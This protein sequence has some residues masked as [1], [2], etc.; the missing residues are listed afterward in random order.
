MEYLVRNS[1]ANRLQARHWYL[2]AR[3]VLTVSAGRASAISSLREPVSRMSTCL[4]GAR[5]EFW[6]NPP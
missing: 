3:L 2:A 4:F 6:V 1:A 5:R